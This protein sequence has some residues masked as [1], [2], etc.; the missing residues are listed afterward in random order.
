MDGDVGP[1]QPRTVWKWKWKETPSDRNAWVAFASGAVRPS[2]A[3]S[4]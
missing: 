3:F 4:P 2:L 1:T